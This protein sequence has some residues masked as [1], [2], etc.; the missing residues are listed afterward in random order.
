MNRPL[1]EEE[2]RELKTTKLFAFSGIPIGAA[3][4]L[5]MFGCVKQMGFKSLPSKAILL[6]GCV[7]CGSSTFCLLTSSVAINR[8]K[9]A[10]IPL[11]TELNELDTLI[12]H[13][14]KTR[15]QII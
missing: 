1:N 15:N 4:G 9:S 11:A 14:N 3:V 12:L 6:A 2:K 8:L 5:I 10:N 13:Q 7:L